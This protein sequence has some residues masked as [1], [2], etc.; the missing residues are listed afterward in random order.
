MIYEK[1]KGQENIIKEEE[2]HSL[3][4]ELTS[5]THFLLNLQKS[6]HTTILDN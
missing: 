6:N 1:L 3:P 5:S 2:D 4:K